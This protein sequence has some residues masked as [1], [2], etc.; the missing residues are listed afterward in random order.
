MKLPEY[1]RS[2]QVPLEKENA[3]PLVRLLDLRNKA[4]R[5]L[6]DTVGPIDVRKLAR[7]SYR[8]RS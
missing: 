2:F 7:D 1:I 8:L 3:G 6:S 4:A 5:G